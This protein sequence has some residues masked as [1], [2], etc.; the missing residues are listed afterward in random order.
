MDDPKPIRVLLAED[1]EVVREGLAA[2]I[3]YQPDMTVVAHARGGEEAV[4]RFTDFQPDITLMDLRM[5][6]MGGVAAIEAIRERFTSARI[7][8]L[9]TYDGD[10]DIH[11]AL[12]A[13]AQGYLLKDTGTE[14]LLN[15]IRTVHAGERYVPADVASR[16]VTRAMAGPSLTERELE[17]LQLLAAGKSNKE[18]GGL[19]FIS[20]G[21]VKTHVAAILEKLGV[22]DR[23]EA[24]VVALKR[25]I[26]HL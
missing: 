16:L 5:P 21:T 23:T 11:R 15:A 17:V 12:R 19:L 3:N 13:G 1:H 9:T 26:I 2:I 8:V 20:E 24:V 6:G 25:G 7:I 18:I 14:D 22:T 4:E 10:E